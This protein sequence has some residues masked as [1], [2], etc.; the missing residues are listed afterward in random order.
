MTYSSTGSSNL[1]L[2]E[3]K[4]SLHFFVPS[5]GRHAARTNGQNSITPENHLVGG[6]PRAGK[7]H[8]GRRDNNC[9]D[10]QS[11]KSNPPMVILYSRSTPGRMYASSGILGIA[12]SSSCFI[13]FSREVGNKWTFLPRGRVFCSEM[14]MMGALFS[15]DAAGE[16]FW[17]FFC[18]IS[19]ARYRCMCR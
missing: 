10:R 4:K 17:T 1:S 8:I 12:G 18:R 15:L 7:S 19:C 11:P 16:G 2:D 9:I 3:R 6:P 14:R 5:P 13:S